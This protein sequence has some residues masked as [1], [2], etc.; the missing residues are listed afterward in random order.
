MTKTKITIV[1]AL[2]VIPGAFIGNHYKNTIAEIHFLNFAQAKISKPINKLPENNNKKFYEIQAIVTAYNT[3]EAQCD[4]TPCIGAGGY[5]CDKD[6]AI[7]CPRNIPLGAWVAIDG[8]LFK[9]LDRTAL[10][11]DGR[12]DISFD[13]DI[14]AARDWGIQHKTILIYEN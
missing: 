9:C 4:S 13:K 10:K 8:K 14:Q 3:T 11:Y 1:L 6:Y 12:Y 7:A 5:I 2:I